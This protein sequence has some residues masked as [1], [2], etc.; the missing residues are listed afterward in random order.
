MIFW[1]TLVLMSSLFLLSC[2]YQ[3]GTSDP[4]ASFQTYLL[5][6]DPDILACKEVAERLE[7]FGLSTNKDK[8]LSGFVLLCLRE[9]LDRRAVSVDASSLGAEYRIT[10][11][12]RYAVE[13]FAGK[14]LVAPSWIR[15]SDS[16]LYDRQNLLGIHNVE[17]TIREEL[18]GSVADQLIRVVSR[19]GSNL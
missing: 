5:S 17:S 3:M 7:S 8:N 15:R 9:E 13:D 1:K 16:F 2:G 4:S 19:V 6:G 18:A 12:F 11:S 14:T 10:Y